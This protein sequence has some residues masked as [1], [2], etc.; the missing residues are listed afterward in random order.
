[1]SENNNQTRSSAQKLR[2]I[3]RQTFGYASLRPGQEEAIKSA[4]AGRDTLAVM[5]TGSGKSAIYQIAGVQI[6]GPTIVVSPLIALQF[7]QLAGLENQEVGGATVINSALNPAE[8]QEAFED[9]EQ[10]KLEFV[11]LAPEQFSNSEVLERLKASKPSLFVVDEAHCI[12]EWGHDFRPSYLRLGAVIEALGH[13]TV[14]ALTAT[15]SPLVRE[16]II[17]RLGMREP[18]LVVQGFDRPNI[19]LGVERFEEELPKRNALLQKVVEAPKPGII[20]TAT[21][22]N[23]EELAQLLV[24]REVKAVAYHAGM[25]SKQREQVQTAFMNDEAEVIVATT[26]FGMGVDKPNVRFVFHHTISEAVDAYYQEIGRAGRDGLEARAVLF[27]RPQDLGLR[28]FFAGSG[29]VDVQ[30]LA[31]VATIVTQAA[32]PVDPREIR[33][34]TELSQTKINAALRHLEQVGVLK[35]LPGGEVV[36]VEGAVPAPLDLC[37]AAVEAAE[38]GEHRKQFVNSQIEM[39]KRYAETAGCRRQYLLN[40]FGEQLE[41]PCGYCDNCQARPESGQEATLPETNSKPFP[42][43]ARVTHKAFGEGMVMGYEDD[44]ILVL[45]DKV[46]Y[47]HLALDLVKHQSLLKPA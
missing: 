12:S 37:G 33:D 5:P 26:A 39:V 13:P 44:K 4:L 3:A 27:Y 10:D 24:E 40:Y 2:R 7:D 28:R 46:G 31:Q 11:L 23:A 20:Y 22:S 34:K 19:W 14:L 47:K 1:M 8:R 36:A 6:P 32:G 41:A 9:L 30:Q 16:E 42:L 18:K 25:N 43:Y 35:N 45:F 38:A 29:L 15:A 21:R 17:Q